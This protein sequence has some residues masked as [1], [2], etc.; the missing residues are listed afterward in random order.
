MSSPG[1]LPLAVRKAKDEFHEF[2]IIGNIHAAAFAD[3]PIYNLLFSKMQPSV[4]L[5]WLWIDNAKQWAAKGVDTVLVLERPDTNEIVGLARYNKYDEAFKPQLWDDAGVVYPDGFDNEESMRMAVPLLKWQKDL[6]DS[7]G[8]FLCK[9]MPFR[10][11]RFGRTDDARL[12]SPV[13]QDFVIAPAHQKQ[14]Y[15][16][17]FLSKIIELAKEER[18]N[19]AL[20]AGPG[21]G[22]PSTTR[23]F[24]SAAR[25]SSLAVCLQNK[26]ISGTSWDSE[27]LE[28]QSCVAR[29]VRL[30]G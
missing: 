9:A 12:L 11:F 15:G 27:K 13:L 14:G 4:A 8:G 3:N 25:C 17:W 10:S 19:I 5:R 30:K 20:T 7:Y 18:M 1:S 24:A 21:K 23:S 22:Y 29:M 16:K 28:S 6:M 2:Q 26:V